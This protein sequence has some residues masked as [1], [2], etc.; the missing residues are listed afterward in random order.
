M[1]P[2]A[3]Q[4]GNAMLCSVQPLCC[5]MKAQP[6]MG[7]HKVSRFVVVAGLHTADLNVHVL[8]GAAC[9]Q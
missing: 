6:G 5:D 7:H 2:C 4:D 9:R 3:V 1:L 8:I